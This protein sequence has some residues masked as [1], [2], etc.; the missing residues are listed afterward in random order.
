M[1]GEPNEA[2]AG[3]VRARGRDAGQ[4]VQ[5]RS[6]SAWPRQPA[7]NQEAAPRAKRR[8]ERRER[9]PAVAGVDFNEHP[10]DLAED[11]ED[12]DDFIAKPHVHDR[13]MKVNMESLKTLT[14]V[15]G[16]ARLARTALNDSDWGGA[17]R[18]KVGAAL[19]KL[20]LT[21]ARIRVPGPDGELIEVPAFYH[22]YVKHKAHRYGVIS[23]HDAFF[24]FMDDEA[25]IRAT[26]SPVRYM[27]MVTPPRPWTRFNAGGYLRTESIVMRG[28]YTTHG[29][30]K[31]QMLALHGE[32]SGAELDGRAVKFQPV[33]DALNVLGRT[34]WR[35]N[36]DVLRVMEE[37][38]HRRRASGRSSPGKRARPTREPLRPVMVA[39]QL[40]A[41]ALPRRRRRVHPFA[42]QGNSNRELHSSVGFLD[43]AAGG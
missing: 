26:L 25:M 42:E 33:L 29:P 31:R 23:W 19:V 3:C 30:S 35:I 17:T 36:E 6:T 15:R 10:S 43:Q 7:I 21:T 12:V 13:F 5:A 22:D 20:L 11:V 34:A 14:T 38:G 24:T 16:V 9:E 27:P 1:F 28:H 4:S 8:P 32:Q 2:Q 37:V 39:G 40:A 41:T 18:S